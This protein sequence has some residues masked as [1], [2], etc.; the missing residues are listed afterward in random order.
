MAKNLNQIATAATS[1]LSTD[2]MYIARS[3][4]GATDD[5]YILG[6]SIISQFLAAANASTGVILRSNGTNFVASTTTFA[7]TYTAG[8]VLIASSSNVVSGVTTANSSVL[9]T[10][11]S[12]IPVQ[13]GTMTNGQMIIGSTGATPVVGTIA[14]GTGITVTTGAGSLTVGLEAN[15]STGVILR[16]NGS[17][18]VASTS[19]FADTYTAGAVLIAGSS[20]AVSGVTTANSSVL[21]TSNAGIPVQSGT[22]T[23]GQMIIGSTGATP[24]VATISAGSGISVTPGAGTL[25]I[26]LSGSASFVYNNVTGATQ[27]MVANAGYIANNSGSTVAFTLPSTAA[28]G[29]I[30][31]VI[32]NC[33]GG[34]S[35][36][37]NA[38]QIIHHAGTSTTAGVTG[39]VVTVERYDCIKLICTVTDLEWS[40]F[41][42]GNLTF[43]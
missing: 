35:I 10:S 22:L 8:A 36:A 7:N 20:N 11:S 38:S 25:T 37:Q 16:S 23:D 2:K 42:A 3:P 29:T 31:E 12:G 5:R 33:S 4:F 15:A 32:G 39:S 26:G 24:Q 6:S 34:W 18:F 1:I 28:I 17:N 9:V 14:A 43:N 13:S 40:T 19:T 41:S 21:V 30:M 27:T